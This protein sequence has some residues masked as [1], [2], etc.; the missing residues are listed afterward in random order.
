MNV[1]PQ[2]ITRETAIAEL[3]NVK[4]SPAEEPVWI[5]G[6]MIWGHPVSFQLEATRGLL[7]KR[8][9]L[10]TGQVKRYR[11]GDSKFFLVQVSAVTARIL[12][13]EEFL[14]SPQELEQRKRHC[15]M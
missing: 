3:T 13:I 15:Y 6:E 8:V 11:E 7:T 2:T 14:L 1:E 12:E 9:R 5:Y 10:M 4:G